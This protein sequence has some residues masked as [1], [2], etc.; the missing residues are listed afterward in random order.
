MCTAVI[1][2]RFTAK[3]LLISL[4]AALPILVMLPAW[5]QEADVKGIPEL[6]EAM[7][8]VE[9]TTKAMEHAQA[10]GEKR[11]MEVAREHNREAQRTMRQNLAN[12][13]GVTSQDIAAMRNAGLGWG[14]ICEE[15]G[16]HPGLLGLGPKENATHARERFNEQERNRART[17]ELTEAT[18]R[19]TRER[20]APK[21]G[22][23]AI[24]HGS[25]GLGL[26]MASHTASHRS[27]RGFAGMSQGGNAQGGMGG[28]SQ[29]GMGSGGGGGG[30]GGGGGGGSGGGGGGGSGGGGGGGR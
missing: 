27:S 21:H 7:Q 15:L 11:A 25:K 6:T 17:R 8:M 16:I 13:A 3:A 20:G 18:V 2:Y 22:M 19:Q 28:G 29:G 26:G 9:K 10:R 5:A 30:S 4:L 1:G 24:S 12:I 14:Q 23:A